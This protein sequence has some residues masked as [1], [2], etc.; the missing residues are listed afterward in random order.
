MTTQ[1]IPIYEGMLA[2][3]ISFLGDGSTFVR[4]YLARPLGTGPY[5]G[6]IVIH[7][8]FGLVEH[9]KEIARRFAARGYMALAPD[10]FTRVGPP[11]PSDLTSLMEKMASLADAQVI[12]DLEGAVGYLRTFPQCSGKVGVIGYCS[13]GRHALLFA[14]NTHSIGAGV[15]CYGGRVI[16][17]QITEA[18]PVAVIDMIPHLSCPLL[19]LFGEADQNPSPAHVARLEEELGEHSKTYEFKSYPADVGHGF[20]ADYRPSYRQE[21]AVDG[22]RRVFA[23]FEKY[24]KS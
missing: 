19:G 22:W 10:L 9:T 5:P 4:A 17:E 21:A 18:Q 16:P 15:D 2:E 8:A 24:L 6:V 7:E 12:N 3:T 14:C 1:E 23:W 20:F 13:G 11:D